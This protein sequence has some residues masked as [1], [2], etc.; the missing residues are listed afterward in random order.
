MKFNHLP[1][2]SIEITQNRP[3]GPAV[4]QDGVQQH[5]QFANDVGPRIAASKTKMVST[6]SHPRAQCTS[7]LG[8]SFTT[9][10][11]AKDN[12]RRRRIGR[13]CC[14][15]LS[16]RRRSSWS[17]SAGLQRIDGISHDRGLCTA[18]LSHLGAGPWPLLV[19][20]A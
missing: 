10:E 16:P 5:R 19:P 13:E 1:P 18:V 3:V 4:V 17:G 7:S 15:S 12:I 6:Q 14:R 20:S 11:Q 8:S 2:I 9:T